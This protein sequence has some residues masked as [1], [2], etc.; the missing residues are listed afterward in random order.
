MEHRYGVTWPILNGSAPRRSYAD[1][2]QA[3]VYIT[4]V[5]GRV[6]I[7]GSH[8]CRIVGKSQPVLIMID[9]IIFTR[10]R[11]LAPARCLSHAHRR[12]STHR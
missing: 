6:E 12:W 11:R 3:T 8:T 10:T 1:P 2:S 7:M 5:R 9:P 4:E